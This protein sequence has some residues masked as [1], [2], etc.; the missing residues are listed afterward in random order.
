MQRV[1]NLATALRDVLHDGDVVVTM[2][3][4]HIGAVSHG[5]VAKLAAPRAVGKRS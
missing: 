1:E 5:L 4:G 2:G 3:A